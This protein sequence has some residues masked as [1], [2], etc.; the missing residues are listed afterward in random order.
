M[1]QVNTEERVEILFKKK[2]KNY[3]KEIKLIK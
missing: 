3:F 1:K 2:F